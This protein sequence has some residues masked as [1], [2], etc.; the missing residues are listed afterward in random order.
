MARNAQLARTWALLSHL[1]GNP[2]G[3]TIGELAR[4]LSVSVRTAYRDLA[5]LEEAGFP[6]Y[7]ERAA[8]E[9]Q[10]R[11]VDGY[12]FARQMPFS[13]DDLLALSLAQDLSRPLAGSWLGQ[14]LAELVRRARAT[15]SPEAAGLLEEA[16]SGVAGRVTASRDYAAHAATLRTLGTAIR[17]KRRVRMLYDS[18]SSRGL[19]PR[20]LA[21][22]ALV[23]Q[24]GAV[25]V[26][27]LDGRRAAVRTFAV[28]R[29][30]AL[31]LTDEPFERPLDFSPERYL[32]S[33]FRI[34]NGEG[35]HRVRIRLAAEV[36]PYVADRVWHPSQRRLALPDGSVELAFEL[37]A[38]EEITTWVLG[39]G[40]AAV[41]IEP[42]ALVDAVRAGAA[43]LA[44]GHGA[45]KM[46][47]AGA[48]A[49]KKRR[50]A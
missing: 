30:R 47:P 36:A 25:Y 28:H 26:V 33:A 49:A 32:A 8:R 31:E 34:V 12:R 48:V 27:G 4:A 15:L 24:D 17:D 5:S 16:R 22:Y 13:L 50:Q 44:A 23:S 45:A 3:V 7:S 35:R 20:V 6:L 14:A 21:P 1:D 19:A 46:A 37:G 43:R 2:A 29:I 38:L 41:V 10:W 9:V 39:L 42:A 11:F 40:G 18:R